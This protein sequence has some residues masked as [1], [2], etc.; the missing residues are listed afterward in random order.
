M[1]GGRSGGVDPLRGTWYQ[2]V[3]LSG[4]RLFDAGMSAA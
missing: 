2:V 3:V 1:V 4:G